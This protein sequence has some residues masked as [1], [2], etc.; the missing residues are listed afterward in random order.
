MNLAVLI[1]RI[2]HV[3]VGVFWA[4]TIFFVVF[5]LEPSVRSV[6]PDGSKVMQA[7]QKRGMLTILPV[8]AVVTILSGGYLYWRLI[9]D[10]GMEWVATPFGTALTV[11]AVASLV[12]FGQGFLFMRP[13][14]IRVGKLGARLG[15]VSDPEEREAL[16]SEIAELKTCSRN[17]SRWVAVWLGIAVV[18][19]AV[20]RY[21]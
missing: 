13:V 6:G 5:L 10:F 11:G 21:V 7:L 2:L 16:L 14:M 18:T 8:A 3:G 1:S 19:M 9:H 12:A 20:A 4:G 17:H 15:D